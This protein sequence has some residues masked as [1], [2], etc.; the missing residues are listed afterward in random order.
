MIV[1]QVYLFMWL[2]K[3]SQVFFLFVS[4]NIVQRKCCLSLWW[5]NFSYSSVPLIVA[6]WLMA[7]MNIVVISSGSG[8]WPVLCQAMTWTST[9]LLSVG[10]IETNF[11][12]IAIKIQTFSFQENAFENV[13]CKISII[14]LTHCGLVL[15]Y[16]DKW[17]GSTLA[18]VMACC[19]MA[20]SHYLNQCWLTISEVR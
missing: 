16:G 10:P 2:K 8:L 15:P 20:P 17:Y 6:R 12:E 14:L 13:V 11:I 5:Q 19:L 7:S 3:K 9:E 18:Q 1:E 4:M